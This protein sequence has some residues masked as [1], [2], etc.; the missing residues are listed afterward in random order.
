MPYRA[1]QSARARQPEPRLSMTSGVLLLGRELRRALRDQRVPLADERA[2]P[3]P[4]VDDVLPPVPE[5]VGQRAGVGD[6]HA[7]V[8]LAVADPERVR[9]PVAADR[10]R[11]HLSCQLVHLS[12]PRGGRQL[13]RRAGL[14]GSR[15]ARVDQ[16]RSQQQSAGQGDREAELALPGGVHG[17]IMA[18]TATVSGPGRPRNL[19]ASSALVLSKTVLMHLATQ[20]SLR[21]RRGDARP[22]PEDLRA[23]ERLRAQ[24]TPAP[25][26]QALYRCQCGYSFK[27]E[28]TTSVGCP[29]CGTSQAW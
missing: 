27:A 22:A 26:D 25:E 13:G 28:V 18:T 12:S 16:R 9:G 4:H 21:A 3:L 6:G 24:R 5:G 10:A 29:H 7:G 11:L 19:Y 2:A 15:E 14:A 17:S 1:V 20:I 8:P 23:S